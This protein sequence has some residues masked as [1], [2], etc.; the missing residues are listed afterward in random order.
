VA[1]MRDD[2]W[3]IGRLHDVVR[4]GALPQEPGGGSVRLA[5]GGQT[6]YVAAG[7]LYELDPDNGRLIALLSSGDAVGDAAAGNI[8]HV[9]VD[10]GHVVASDGTATFMRDKSGRWQRQ[11][12]AISDVG[13]LRP[14]A[15]V[16]G[17][18]D[19]AYGLTWD[20]NLVRFEL[21]A[22]NQL[23]T[24]WAAADETPDLALA[25]DFAID[26]RIHVLLEDGRMLTFSRGALVGT[27]APFIAPVLNEPA[28]L[29]DAPL[30]NAFYIVDRNGQIG[31]NVGRIVRVDAA[32]DAMQYLTPAPTPGDLAS[33]GAAVSLASAE[34]LVVDELS[35]TVYWVA[36]GDIWRARLPSG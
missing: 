22:E 12:M 9:S 7:S 11:P 27:L 14:D 29:A 6:L 31:E 18:G 13:G 20:G 10:D 4:L 5:L 33:S 35:G 26:G 17:W 16:V 2:V 23:A 8:R 24:K 19:A 28:F 21:S 36:G 30:A 25:R 15:P 32:G 1:R 3:R 34:D